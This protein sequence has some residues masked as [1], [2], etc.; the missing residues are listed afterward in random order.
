ML[1]HT[2]VKGLS[3]LHVTVL[4]AL[5][6]S[7]PVVLLCCS[8]IKGPVMG[9]LPPA[10]G[11]CTVMRITPTWLVL[12]GGHGPRKQPL[13]DI[14]RLHL[15]T[16]SWRPP[17]K[18][19]D[20]SSSSSNGDNGSAQL[21]DD[22]A[23][24]ELVPDHGCCATLGCAAEA[25]I[26]LGGMHEGPYGRSIMARLDMLL[27]GPVI[28]ALQPNQHNAS[29]GFSAG[30]GALAGGLPVLLQQHFPLRH[31]DAQH[32]RA[33][34]HAFATTSCRC[35]GC[36]SCLAAK[37]AA[38]GAL[39]CCAQRPSLDGAPVQGSSTDKG[40]TGMGCVPRWQA[41][42]GPGE[43]LPG[44]RGLGAVNTSTSSS[45]KS[46]LSGP[47]GWSCEF[48]I[49]P[50][51]ATPQ[52]FPPAAALGL[53]QRG[54]K[55]RLVQDTKGG[56]RQSENCGGLDAGSDC[57]WQTTSSSS[58]GRGLQLLLALFVVM[59]GLVLMAPSLMMHQ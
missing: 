2:R 25:C 17:A 26:V 37:A 45:A 19:L 1:L 49:E 47:M 18:I 23:Q 52:L 42:G 7:M 8:W 9:Y 46:M 4:T 35:G 50:A 22:P 34:W 36:C 11:L 58:D 55:L 3:L 28:P 33:A 40:A 16:L 13:Q 20:G 38:S 5:C 6:C 31:E 29:A 12:L 10:R 14:Q 54:Q 21:V 43:Q 24:H 27:P 44:P 51:P 15:P 56:I 57:V 59:I 30:T 32:Q 39:A 41:V 53:A 48:E